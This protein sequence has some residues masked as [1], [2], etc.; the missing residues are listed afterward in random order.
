MNI[1]NSLFIDVEEKGIGD[2]L[3]CIILAIN[4]HKRYENI[5][6]YY[7]AIHYYGLD[8]VIKKLIKCN[9]C[10]NIIT[11]PNP[12]WSNDNSLE[13]YQK[14]FNNYSNYK[15]FQTIDSNDY[16]AL[17]AC[18]DFYED[19]IKILNLKYNNY[20]DNIKYFLNEEDKRIN[21]LFYNK[22]IESVGNDYIVVFM[23]STRLN[24][25]FTIRDY[26]SDFNKENYKIVYFSNQYNEE[27]KI[28]IKNILG[29][30]QH[31]Y[32]Y[33][34]I[35]ENAKSVHF[36]NSYPAHYFNMVFNINK[37]KYKNIDKNVY[38]RGLFGG[39]NDKSDNIHINNMY[40]NGLKIFNIFNAY[41]PLLFFKN[42]ELESKY[43]TIVG[44]NVLAGAL[45][46]NI[47]INNNLFI[48]KTS[49]NSILMNLQKILQNNIIIN[50]TG[51]SII[52]DNFDN[53]NFIDIDINSENI[54]IN[55][56]SNNNL[57]IV[58]LKFHSTYYMK[59][60]ERIFDDNNNIISCNIENANIDQLK[61][62]E[63]LVNNNDID[64]IF[65][66]RFNT[67]K[68]NFINRLKNALNK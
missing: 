61:K 3:Y 17:I 14:Y 23:D 46:D 49:D 16:L 51:L 19:S 63:L 56:L 10:N 28:M 34:K 2:Y 33:H 37:T 38:T 54:E 58:L 50:E 26:K 13:K 27:N 40:D 4:V 8:Y 39:I 43:S 31:L 67:D 25:V 48:K 11:I 18:H 57:N 36:I 32:Y 12:K 5:Y 53:L 62:L 64:Y 66:Y 59:L 68:K 60:G 30:Q 6:V 65:P 35:V 42:I 45:Q 15:F 7:G 47:T 21:N 52:K 20:F 1:K 44:E 29:G 55:N 24:D 9:N 41:Y 22:L